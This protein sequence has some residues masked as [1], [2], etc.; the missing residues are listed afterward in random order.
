MQLFL[1]FRQAS[2]ANLSGGA[3]TTVCARR[4]FTIIV[5]DNVSTAQIVTQVPPLVLLLLAAALLLF[6]RLHCWYG[7]RA[8]L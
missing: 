7:L 5:Q 4:T 3:E 8:G 1:L 2:V 6:A